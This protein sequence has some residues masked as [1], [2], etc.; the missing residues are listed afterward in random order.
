MSRHILLTIAYKGTAYHG[1]QV[2]QNAVTVAEV[3]QQALRA[4]LGAPQQFKGCSR[5]DAGVHALCFCVSFFTESVIPCEKLP[6]A[7]NS[8]LPA[9][10][11]ATAAREVEP[12]FHARYSCIGKA[13]LYRVRNAPVAS[14][15]SDDVC[16][17]VWPQLALAPMQQA[18]A[19]L[20]GTHDFASF[21]SAGST[22]EAEGGSTVRTVLQ[23]SVKKQGDEIRF[24]I[25][26]DG[27][28]YNM[29]RIL[30]GTL[31]EVGAG[32]IA[33][34][35]VADILAACDRTKAGPTAPAKGLALARVCYPG[36]V[37]DGGGMQ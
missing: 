32:R 30:V 6:L 5:T 7:L 9:D 21:M 37:A 34:A 8:H 1:F 23:F 2:Q 18:A 10:I 15:F 19:L 16:W 13:Y 24:E 25:E 35:Q 28:L 4:V 27:Y 3:L 31:A 29:V 36:F 33:A 12:G 14:P 20:T 11:R 22:I 17:R 26:A